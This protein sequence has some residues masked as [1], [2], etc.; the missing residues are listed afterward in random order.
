MEIS[1][2]Q[3][4]A[5]LTAIYPLDEAITYPLLG[6]FGEVGEFANK[7]KKVLRDGAEFTDEDKK[8]ELGDILWYIANL[9]SD[10][11]L[12]LEDIA[13]YNLDKLH[14]RQQ[15]GRLGGSGDNR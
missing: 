3:A 11:G 5:L 13:Q 15:R 7:Y 2:Y 1:K 9:A 12:K 14:D 6:L 8:A 10:C 4:E